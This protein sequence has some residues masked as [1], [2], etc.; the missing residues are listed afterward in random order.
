MCYD[1]G[2]RMLRLAMRPGHD[3]WHA[4]D[5]VHS[6]RLQHAQ[7]SLSCRRVV[8]AAAGLVDVHPGAEQDDGGGAMRVRFRHDGWEIWRQQL[9]KS[10]GRDWCAEN[11]VKE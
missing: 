5:T 10:D 9:D 8:N 2:F 6:R 4:E 1:L 11:P 7:R 3:N